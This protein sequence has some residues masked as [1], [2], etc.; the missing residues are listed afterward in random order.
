MRS[1]IRRKDIGAAESIQQIAQTDNTGAQRDLLPCFSEGAA[2]IRVFV[3]VKD[4]IFYI[5]M[6]RKR[7]YVLLAHN[8]VSAEMRQLRQTFRGR[9][10]TTK[11]FVQILRQSI[12]VQ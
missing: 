11:F 8:A 4:D 1:H 7:G 12:V 10:V 2:A 5:C 3:V 9:A 6:K